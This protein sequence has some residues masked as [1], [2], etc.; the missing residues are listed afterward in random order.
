LQAELSAT[1]TPSR[2]AAAYVQHCRRP[3]EFAREGSGLVE[4]GSPGAR[5]IAV[6][7]KDVVDSTAATSEIQIIEVEFGRPE[8]SSRSNFVVDTL[9]AQ[10]A[11]TLD[12]GRMTALLDA[13]SCRPRQTCLG[14]PSTVGVTPKRER[15]R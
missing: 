5:A 14:E 2:D 10:V 8:R 7:N 9:H 1:R 4:A 6:Q 3:S 12:W 13:P 11:T 15:K